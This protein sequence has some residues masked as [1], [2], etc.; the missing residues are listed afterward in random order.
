MESIEL[1]DILLLIALAIVAMVVKLRRKPTSVC[2]RPPIKMTAKTKYGVLKFRDV[3][4]G[5]SYRIYIIRSVSYCG[6]A[7]GGHQTHRL[8]DA[9]GTYICWDGQLRTKED[10]IAVASIWVRSTVKYISSGVW[11]SLSSN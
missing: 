7:E 4:R 1:S 8:S 10:V 11:P 6:R 5:S 3:W 9:A 2:L